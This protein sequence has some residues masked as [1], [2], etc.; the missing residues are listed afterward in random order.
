MLFALLLWNSFKIE[1]FLDSSGK[2]EEVRSLNDN[3][4]YQSALNACFSPLTEISIGQGA[5]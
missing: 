4:Q 5:T 2:M 3:Y 1:A